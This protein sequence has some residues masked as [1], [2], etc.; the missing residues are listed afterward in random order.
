[1]R[2]FLLLVI[3]GSPALYATSFTFTSCTGGTTTLN[4][5]PGHSGFIGPNFWLVADAAAPFPIYA[6]GVSAYVGAGAGIS[7]PPPIELSVTAIAS[8]NV[9]YGTS[10]PLRLGFIK[11][12]HR[13]G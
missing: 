9:T 13:A 6:P 3:L 7:G 2:R 5:C 10:G 12:R 8:E 4:P 1:M 11:L